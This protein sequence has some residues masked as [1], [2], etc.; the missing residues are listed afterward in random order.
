[1]V[2]IHISEEL[3]V[4]SDDMFSSVLEIISGKKS[5]V[6]HDV[7]NNKMAGI[8]KTYDFINAHKGTTKLVYDFIKDVYLKA[9]I[10]DKKAIARTLFLNF[11]L[12]IIDEKFKNVD[13]LTEKLLLIIFDNVAYI[14]NNV[15]ELKET[16]QRQIEALNEKIGGRN[17]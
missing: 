5:V 11:N 16:H 12:V 1:M 15:K 17:E 6:E 14:K 2:K 9:K 10:G 13:G 3:V 8:N 7:A 4:I